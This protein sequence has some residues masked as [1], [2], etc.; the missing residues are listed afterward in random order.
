MTE[1]KAKKT[2]FDQNIYGDS[3]DYADGIVDE[4]DDRQAEMEAKLVKLRETA[5]KN[6]LIEETK[7]EGG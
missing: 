2:K 6:Q 3:N 5:N 4:V 1:R 7:M